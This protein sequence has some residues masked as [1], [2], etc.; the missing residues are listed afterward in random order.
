MKTPDDFDTGTLTL[1][2]EALEAGR[3]TSADPEERELQELCLA[4]RADSPAPDKEFAERMRERLAK[5][6]PPDPS[7]AVGRGRRAAE[8]LRGTLSSAAGRLRPRRLSPAL[9]GGVAA[10]ALAVVVGASVLSQTLGGGDR[11]AGSSVEPAVQPA[12]PESVARD[13]KTFETTKAD[14]A[15]GAG[16]SG[17]GGELEEQPLS[18]A[19][20]DADVVIPEPV[21]PSPKQGNALGEQDRRVERSARMTLAAP[22]KQLAEVGSRIADTVRIHDGFVLSSSLTTGESGSRGGFFELRVPLAELD[23]TLADLS[24]LGEVRSLTQDE[25]DVT[26]SFESLEDRL[27][28]EL[29]RRKSL[30]SRLESADTDLQAQAIRRQLRGVNRTI[31]SIRADQRRLDRRTSWAAVSVTLEKGR[32]DAGSAITQ[33]L[34]DAVAILE[35]AFGIALRVLAVLLPLAIVGALIWLGAR[36]VRRRRRE[37]ALD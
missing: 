30:L 17:A 37:S 5:G 26:A 4:I 2:D 6:F 19:P 7:S 18:I 3:A 15:S 22:E 32:G 13:E 33:A 11:F 20:D 27:K 35:T 16:A 25:Q 36:A 23:A 1:I 28:A 21:P 9:V 10:L 12:A 24:D 31:N 29:A 34:E 14:R 8:H